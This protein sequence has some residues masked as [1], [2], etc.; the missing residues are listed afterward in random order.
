MVPKAILEPKAPKA[1]KAILEPKAP[2][3]ILEIRALD[4][5]LGDLIIIQQFIR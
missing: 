4:L 5:H 3:G 2:K 1:P